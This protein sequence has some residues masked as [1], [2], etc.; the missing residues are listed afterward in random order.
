MGEKVDF[1]FHMRYLLFL[2]E[3]IIIHSRERQYTYTIV[4]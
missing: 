1:L 2:L 3:I 4:F